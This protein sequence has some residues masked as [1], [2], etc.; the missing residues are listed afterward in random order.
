MTKKTVPP[1][2]PREMDLL[3]M[4]A[5]GLA[6][7]WLSL[8]KLQDAKKGVKIIQE[9]QAATNEPFIR[10]LLDIVFSA[11]PEETVRRLALAKE[12]AL[13]RDIG[14]KLTII[15]VTLL[16]VAR[17]ENP[18]KTL[19]AMLSFFPFP[20]LRE[21]E[22]MD[23]ANQFP[24]RIK[25]GELDPAIIA[26]VDH[27]ARA[28]H[29]ILRLLH[30]A[31]TARRDGKAAAVP[32]LKHARSLY[33]TE[34]WTLLSDGFDPPFLERRLASQRAQLLAATRCK[35]RMATEMALGIR[36]KFSYE[37]VFR[38]ARSFMAD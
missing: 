4:P 23:T 29:L 2:A 26:D 36:N 7:Y 22:A 12:Q 16:S 31:L 32:L 33:F 6:A 30:Y 17:N 20:P 38:I 1:P 15:A 9:E 27:A 25:R 3:E 5:S 24:E 34:N 14:R 28:E 13:L 10:H 18:R 8:K 35:M 21:A 37:D 19:V 11:L